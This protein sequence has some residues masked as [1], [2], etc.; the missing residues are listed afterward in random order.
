MLKLPTITT[1]DPAM[2]E[3]VQPEDPS[4]KKVLASKRRVRLAALLL[5]YIALND[6]HEEELR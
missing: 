2:F 3:Q 4:W 1:V 5:R 6:R